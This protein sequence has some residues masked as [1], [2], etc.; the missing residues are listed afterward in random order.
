M[1]TSQAYAA[2]AADS[3]LLAG[4]VIVRSL[5]G[6]SAV[7]SRVARAWLGMS[8]RPDAE[9][10][11]TNTRGVGKRRNP[12]TAPLS[13][14]D[15]ARRPTP[16]LVVHRHG[17]RRSAYG[18][19]PRSRMGHPDRRRC[20]AL[21]AARAREL[22]GRPVVVDDPAQARGVSVGVSWVSAGPG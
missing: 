18:R 13:S 20:R 6:P 1:L 22:P 7:F 19:V 5:P 11:L 12:A 4:R 9:E 15:A 21:R 14:P 2:R 8:E 17:H 3:H 10:L 16:L